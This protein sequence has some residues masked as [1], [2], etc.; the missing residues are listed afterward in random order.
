MGS[1]T[2]LIS[3][4]VKPDIRNCVRC[5]ASLAFSDVS[6]NFACAYSLSVRIMCDHPSYERGYQGHDELFDVDIL[7]ILDIKVKY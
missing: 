1:V 6:R 5:L 3:L 7:V 4:A 2:R